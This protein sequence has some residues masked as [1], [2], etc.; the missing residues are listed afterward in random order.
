MFQSAQPPS[1]IRHVRELSVEEYE[2]YE[3][4]PSVIFLISLVFIFLGSTATICEKHSK[5]YK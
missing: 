5:I 1:F 3:A 2:L 4:H